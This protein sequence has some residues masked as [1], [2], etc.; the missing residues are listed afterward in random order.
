MLLKLFND[1][2]RPS[3]VNNEHYGYNLQW[4]VTYVW[5]LKQAYWELSNSTYQDQSPL[6]SFHLIARIRMSASSVVLRLWLHH[7]VLWSFVECEFWLSGCLYL[8]KTIDT[9]SVRCFFSCCTLMLCHCS[10]RKVADGT[11]NAHRIAGTAQCKLF[12]SNQIWSPST[13]KVAP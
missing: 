7:T 3:Q 4:A 12:F 6:N 13:N 10:P 1:Q 2:I 11:S 5:C 8:A 9:A